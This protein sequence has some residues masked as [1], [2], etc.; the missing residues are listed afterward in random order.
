[1]KHLCALFALVCLSL[2]AAASSASGATAG[3]FASIC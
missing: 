1:M 3:H 2:A